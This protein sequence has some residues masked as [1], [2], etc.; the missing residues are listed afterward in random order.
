MVQ[1]RRHVLEVGCENSVGGADAQEVVHV[2][3]PAV[4]LGHSLGDERQSAEPSRARIRRHAGSVPAE[5]ALERE[6]LQAKLRGVS[7]GDESIRTAEV[8][9]R[10]A[11][12]A[13]GDGH[14]VA[15]GDRPIAYCQTK[16]IGAGTGE[17]RCCRTGRR[18][19][20]PD[21]AWTADL[22]PRVGQ[23]RGQRPPVIED[24]SMERGLGSEGDRLIGAC[25]HGRCAIEG[26]V[27]HP[28]RAIRQRAVD[29][30]ARRI[31]DGRASVLVHAPAAEQAGRRR[32]FVV[33]RALDLRLRSGV[34]PDASLVEITGEEARRRPR[35]V[36]GAGERRRLR[37]VESRDC[38]CGE[39]QRRFEVAIE[40]EL[41]GGF[42][43]IVRRRRVVPV[44]VGRDDRGSLHR[45]VRRRRRARAGALLEIGHE[46]AGGLLNAEEIV[47]VSGRAL[48]ASALGDEGNARQAARARGR[49][50]ARAGAPEPGF[51]GEARG[52]EVRSAPERDVVV[53]AV[54]MYARG[55][56]AGRRIHR[57]GHGVLAS[58]GAVVR[59]EKEDVGA[60]HRERRRCHGVVCV[61]EGHRA[62]PADDAP[63]GR[64]R[65]WRRQVIV[66]DGAIE[67]GRRGQGNRLVDA[68]IHHGR[69]VG[70]R[71][72]DG[73]FVEG[74]Q[75]AVIRRQAQHVSA[76][77]RKRGG[78]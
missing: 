12:Q 8:D 49:A 18:R 73:Q 57:D 47:H 74:T 76:L 77:R 53:R 72:D 35:G 46:E 41:P 21:G 58:Q 48:A 37:A 4:I 42:A 5:P 71:H 10:R 14:V 34:I 23:R 36:K 2:H 9:R 38:S 7:E 19:S 78:R 56:P 26:R 27:G 60:R 59:G 20:K 62:R 52:A 28:R 45:V 55:C 66:G 24:G 6:R 68:G 44:P 17:C 32:E 33:H 39:R 63:G 64:A 3:R 75:G 30:A 1:A 13:H 61:A 43:R 70:G 51:Q 31:G 16:H 69:L 15:H 67:A 11:R 54:E 25:I 29:A 22:C 40:V 50:N 65:T